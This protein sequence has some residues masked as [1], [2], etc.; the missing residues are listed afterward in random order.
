MSNP[1]EDLL[2]VLAA[3]T[4]LVGMGNPWRN[5]DGVGVHVVRRLA[6]AGLPSHLEAM[7]VEDVIESYVFDI[8]AKAA[9]NVV[10]VDAADV[11]GARPGSIVFG[12][13]GDLEAAT[14]NVSTHKL[15]LRTVEDVL[16]RSGKETYLLGIVAADIDFGDSVSP[17]VLAAADAVVDIARSAKKQDLS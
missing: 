10:L 8:A 13:V 12:R 7:V 17:A 1:C 5:D 9:G 6:E 16:K 15:A 4:C 14:S 3:P 2:A 11:P